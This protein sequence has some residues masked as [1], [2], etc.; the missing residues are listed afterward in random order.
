MPLRSDGRRNNQRC[1]Y[2]IHGPR[3]MRETALPPF[4][5]DENF[6]RFHYKDKHY[7]SF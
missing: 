3:D 5:S 4:A 1:R 6:L 2:S 7:A